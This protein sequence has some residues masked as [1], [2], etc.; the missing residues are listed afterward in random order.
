MAAECG[1]HDM[2]SVGLPHRHWAIVLLQYPPPVVVDDREEPPL[3]GMLV[4]LAHLPGDRTIAERGLHP[5]PTIHLEHAA[6]RNR[7]DQSDIDLGRVVDEVGSVEAPHRVREH[8]RAEQALMHPVTLHDA[9]R[10]ISRRDFASVLKL[11]PPQPQAAA[12]LAEQTLVADDYLLGKDHRRVTRSIVCR[13]VAR[14]HPELPLDSRRDRVGG[15]SQKNRSRQFD[16][17]V[18]PFTHAR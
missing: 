3:G 11:E 5:P 18:Q 14:S 16:R 10:W 9:H 4:A 2:P 7:A 13:V 6:C 8:E 1:I 15:K 17:P 12:R